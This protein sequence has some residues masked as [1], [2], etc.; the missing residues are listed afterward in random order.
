MEMSAVLAKYL[1]ETDA[2]RVR[3]CT[4]VEAEMEQQLLILKGTSIKKTRTAGEKKK[5]AGARASVKIQLQA[6]GMIGSMGKCSLPC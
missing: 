4:F 5:R 3:V 1:V 6:K 2:V